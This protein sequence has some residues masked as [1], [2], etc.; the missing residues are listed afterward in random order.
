MARRGVEIYIRAQDKASKAFDRI[1]TSSTKALSKLRMPILAVSAATAG[2]AAAYGLAIKKGVE[3][4]A[5]LENYHNVLTAV[6]KSQQKAN[7]SMQWA[8]KLAAKTPFQIPEIV[9]ATARLE[10]YGIKAKEVLL[11]LG[12]MAAATG[13]SIM[14]AVEALADAQIEKLFWPIKVVQNINILER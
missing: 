10:T 12:D 11:P 14:Q 3:Y 4:N 8:I 13:K 7:Q 5:E 1:S 6:F 9:Q 2:A